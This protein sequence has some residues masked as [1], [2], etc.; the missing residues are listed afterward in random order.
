MRLVRELVVKHGKIAF[1]VLL[2]I[3][4]AVTVALAMG[5]DRVEEQL[6]ESLVSEETAESTVTEPVLGAVEPDAELV[7]NEDGALYTLMATYY[8]AL[9]NGD[10]DTIRTIS[11]YVEDTESIRIRELSKY[12]E[13]YPQIEIYTKEGPAEGSY[14]A[15]VYTHVTFYGHEQRV[16]GLMT[17]YVCTDEAGNLYM[18]ENETAEDVLEYVRTVSLQDDVVELANTTN[19]EYNDLLRANLELADYIGALEKEVSQATGEA[20]A[21]QIAAAEAARQEQEEAASTQNPQEGQQN[22]ALYARATATV[23][24]RNSDS[25][26]AEKLG[27]L[28]DG[29]KIQILEQRPNGWSK[30]LFEG[31]EGFIKSEYLQVETPVAESSGGGNGTRTATANLNLRKDASTSSDKLGVVIGGDTVEV[32]SQS[33]EWSQIRYNGT[34]GYVK[35][36]YL[37]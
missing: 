2:V 13:S 4:V 3:A 1:P 11:N 22:T 19:T 9:A 36:E 21:A 6:E 12:I 31:K 25:Q 37:E 30:V 35:T 17:F 5:I 24:V 14:I 18:N 33:G 29:E 32:L 8:N 16:P 28:A 23:N 34:V 7:R 15:Y 27:Q 26:Q 10:V 20:L